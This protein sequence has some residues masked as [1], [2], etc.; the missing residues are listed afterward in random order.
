MASNENKQ[1]NDILAAKY[2]ENVG[3]AESDNPLGK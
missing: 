2:V 1:W 3:V